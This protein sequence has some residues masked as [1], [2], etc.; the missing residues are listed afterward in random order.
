MAANAAYGQ[1]R[2]VYHGLCLK[3][4][5]VVVMAAAHVAAWVITTDQKAVHTPNVD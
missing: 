5:A 2:P 1:Y 4:G 3:F